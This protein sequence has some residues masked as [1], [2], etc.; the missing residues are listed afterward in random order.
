VKVAFRTD[1]SAVIGTGHV[2]RCLALAQELSSRGVRI[3]FVSSE[4]PAQLSSLITDA[5]YALAGNV[6]TCDWLVVDHYALGAEWE[7]EQRERAAKIMAIDDLAGRAHD[8]DLLLDQN[9]LAADNPYRGSVPAGTRVCL[10]PRYALLRRA[11]AAERRRAPAR[12]GAL[13]RVFV[14]FG[15]SDPRN[16]TSAALDA[17]RPRAA[18]LEAV[19]V[20]IGAASPHAENVAARCRSLP[21]A[22]LHHGTDEMPAMLARADL[23]IGA[24]GTMTWERACMGVP[25]IAFG[26]AENQI[27]VLEGLLRAEYAWGDSSMP[28]PDVERIASWIDRALHSAP[29]MRGMAAR[30]AELVDG[31]GARRIAEALLSEPIRFR[32]ATLQDA[33]DILRWRNDPRVRSGSHDSREID[34]QAHLAWMQRV[35]ADPSR[36]LLVAQSGGQPVGVVRFDLRDT[37]ATISAYRTPDASD[38][39]RGLIRAATAWLRRHRPDIREV[40]AEIL[41]DNAASLAAFRKAGYTGAKGVLRYDMTKG[42]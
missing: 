15:G 28:E 41:A 38:A 40:R 4:L 39:S 21:N 16:H 22:I 32:L 30:A 26:V 37:T 20:V 17:L 7:R 14:C 23:A 27:P 10:G 12:T 11:F 9:V 2:M 6:P 8:C 29:Q 24:G 36:I 42:E 34:S 1:A 3:E 5:G 18:Q 13:R 31:Q 35:L 25:T 19:E 33:A